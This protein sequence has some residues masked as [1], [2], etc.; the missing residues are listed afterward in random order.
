MTITEWTKSCDLCHEE[1][2]GY[3]EQDG[4]KFRWAGNELILRKREENGRLVGVSRFYIC[5]KCVSKYEELLSE[6]NKD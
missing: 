5:P 6:R 3:F 4:D 2:V 1:F